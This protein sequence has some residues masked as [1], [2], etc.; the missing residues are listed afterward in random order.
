MSSSE[1]SSFS[2]PH[3]TNHTT[4]WSTTWVI[5]TKTITETSCE[6]DKGCSWVSV[7]TRIVTIPNNIETPMV[8]N[9]VDSTTTESTSQSP[10]GIFSE[11]EYLLKQNLL[12]LLLL[13]QIQVFQQLKVR[14]NLLLKET[15]EMVLM[16][17]HLL[18]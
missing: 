5:E 17:H 2:R 1:I 4:L 8:T 10:S 7:S 9:T 12:L 6:G 18:M 13:K 11:S 3:Y 16:N 15:T 14:L